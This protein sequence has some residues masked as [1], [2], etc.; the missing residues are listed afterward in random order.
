S[1]DSSYKSWVNEK[2]EKENKGLFSDIPTS[3][4]SLVLAYL[5]SKR[6]ENIGFGFDNIETILKKVE[7]EQFELLSAIEKSKK[8]EITGEIGDLL[9]AIVNL[10]LFLKIHPE[11]ALRKTCLKF[12]KRLQFIEETLYKE[13]KSFFDT[14]R[15]YLEKLWEMSK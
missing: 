12:L 10:S 4:P 9:L 15:E 5:I 13:G 11:E 14:D 3:S 8:E 6:A 2:R 7:E 1:L